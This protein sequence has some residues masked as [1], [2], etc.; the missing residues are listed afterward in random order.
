MTPAA[1]RDLCT[2]QV[3]ALV[4]EME[5]QPDQAAF[6][7][8]AAAAEVLALCEPWESARSLRARVAGVALG[9]LRGGLLD[10]AAFARLEFLYH[11][12]LFCYFASLAPGFRRSDAAHTGELV[13]R[14]LT[15]RSE[16]PVITSQLVASYLAA[17]GIER[18]AD[19]LGPRDLRLVVDKRVLRARSDDFDILTLTMAAQLCRV[20]ARHRERMPRL[21]PR[22][23][24]VQSVREGHVNW[25]AILTL[26]CASVFGMPP[27]LSEGATAALSTH[28]AEAGGLLPPPEATF[29]DNDYV[30]RAE[31]GLRIRSSIAAF[32]LLH[33]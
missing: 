19:V 31:R 12:S 8:L 3:E 27:W 6:S 10:D 13:A 22:T 16:L 14:G 29:A 4:G 9:W 20:A 18:G 30:Q 11:A 21:F 32:A 2:A 17:C 26:L 1:M 28:L 15:S 23:L 24:L 7:D 33:A 25:I 5:R